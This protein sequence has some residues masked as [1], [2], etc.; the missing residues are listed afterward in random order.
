MV[1]YKSMLNCSWSGIVFDHLEDRERRAIDGKEDKN[2]GSMLR[3][4]TTKEE[5]EERK[6]AE[7]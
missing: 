2:K 1:T 6:E 5:D 7:Y 3:I 4:R